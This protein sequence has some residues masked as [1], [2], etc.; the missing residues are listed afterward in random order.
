MLGAEALAKK[1]QFL[2]TPFRNVEKIG[3]PLGETIT[4]EELMM[5]G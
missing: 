4:E 2:Y 3:R 1:R 5:F